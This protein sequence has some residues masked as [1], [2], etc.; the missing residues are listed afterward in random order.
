L[1]DSFNRQDRDASER[2][3]LD[4]NKYTVPGIQADDPLVTVAPVLERYGR[5]ADFL[6]DAGADEAEWKALRMSETSGRP[7]GSST[8]LGELEE[9]TGRTL[10]PRKRGPKPKE[11]EN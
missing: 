1:A 8:W 9:K 5:F 6:G 10:K 3:Q 7:L 11:A 4:R 2:Q